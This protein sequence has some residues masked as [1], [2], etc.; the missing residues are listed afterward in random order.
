MPQKATGWVFLIAAVAVMCLFAAFVWPTLYRYD[1]YSRH[2]G[3]GVSSTF[4]VRINRFTG[5]AETLGTEG[6]YEM[7]KTTA[8]APSASRQN[9]W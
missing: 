1:S 2:Y 7:K 6:W 4:I 3:G 8:P 9:P 5:T